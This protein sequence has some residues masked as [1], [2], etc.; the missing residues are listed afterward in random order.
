MGPGWV[1]GGAQSQ[2]RPVDLVRARIPPPLSFV[3]PVLHQIYRPYLALR[4]PGNTSLSTSLGALSGRNVLL[5]VAIDSPE[6]YNEEKA[7]YAA[8][9]EGPQGG[10]SL[11]ELKAS[12]GTGLY[13]E[14][15][16][17]Y[18]QAIVRFF[19]TNLPKNGGAKPPAKKGL[20]V[21]ER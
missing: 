9:P 20:Q 21:L 13:A 15:K 4:P 11:L 6:R 19:T 18:D 1:C 10:K 3:M 14:D 2:I 7:L 5:I 12:V 8:L 16:K 17:T